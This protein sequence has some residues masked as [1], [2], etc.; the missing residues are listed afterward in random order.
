M[1]NPEDAVSSFDFIKNPRLEELY[2]QQKEIFRKEG[3]KTKEVYLFHGTAVA[4]ID[5]ILEENLSPDF[6]S[7]HQGNEKKK[8]LGRESTSRSTLRSL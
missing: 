6:T 7:E 8:K 5:S 2:V 3:K 4:N 1:A